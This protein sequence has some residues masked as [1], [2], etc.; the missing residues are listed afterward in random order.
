MI[1]SLAHAGVAAV[2]LPVLAA[3]VPGLAGAEEAVRRF[4]LVVG[5][6]EGVPAEEPLRYAAAD[7]HR[8][9]E[10]LRDLGGVRPADLLLLTDAD[11]REVRASLIDL[12][13]RIRSSPTPALLFVF[14]SGH[15]DA[16]SLH[17]RGT[18]LP[19]RELKDLVAGSAAR[20]RV[21]VL[22]ACR[23]GAITRVKGGRPGPSFEV[24]AE[25]PLRAE[26]LAILTSSAAGEDAQE[27]DALQ[28][29][30][31]THYLTSALRGAADRD[32]D[33]VVTLAESFSYAAKRTVAA[34]AATLP[35]PQHPT[36][37]FDLGGRGDLPLTRIDGGRRAGVLRLMAPGHYLVQRRD[38]TGTVVAE[39]QAEE[40]GRRLALPAATYHLVR[41][42]QDAVYT[43]EVAVPL[44]RELKVGPERFRRL[45]QVR[46]VRKGL[47][48]RHSAGVILVQGGLRSE[49]QGL[50]VAARIEVGARLVLRHL[51]VG[52]R[53]GVSWSRAYSR[54]L[55]IDTRELA[56]GVEGTHPFDLGPLTVAPGIEVWGVRFE[57]RFGEPQ[58]PDRV[59]YAL[60]TGPI[61]QLEW[62]LGA[63][64][65]L[66]LETALSTYLLPVGND[67][68]GGTVSAL[69]FGRLTLGVGM[70]F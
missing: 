2:L 51:A 27:S 5:A 63:A 20:A 18:K 14:Y 13:V 4:A 19:L 54:R 23:S 58:T 8:V 16:E 22:D 21:L 33:G 56:L 60:A 34:T 52:A 7:A 40:G 44:H 12:N 38:G 49:I 70:E 53:V 6:S 59:T 43:A 32:G 65:A 36:Y 42:T 69:F 30:F 37:R 46:V 45:P 29:S 64:L 1:R 11:A 26:G 61:V 62:P 31:F 57:Q 68:E 25:A 28:A 15:A 35:G 24:E 17:L 3:G 48:P 39:V 41:R 10:V 66:R 9:A 47:G 50:G 67:L 55:A